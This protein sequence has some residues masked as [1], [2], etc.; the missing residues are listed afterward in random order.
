M[1]V[2]NLTQHKATADQIA[3]G[4]RDLP[5]NLQSELSNLLTFEK[6]PD[7]EEI[8]L[9][10]VCVAELAAEVIDDD[11][12]GVMIGGAPFFMG[13]L[14]RALFLRGII[15]MYAFSKRE[16]VEKQMPD[17]SVQKQNVFRHGGFVVA[18]DPDEYDDYA[19]AAQ[20]AI[21]TE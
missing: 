8:H 11:D 1:K 4:V 21:S 5:D 14:E 12:D 15:P 16:S 13:A 3:V 2:L 10:A 6:K 7:Q 19:K 20:A 17:G 9:R 18:A